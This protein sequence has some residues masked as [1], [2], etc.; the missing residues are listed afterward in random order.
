MDGMYYTTFIALSLVILSVFYLSRFVYQ[1]NSEL[2][3]YFKSFRLRQTDSAFIKKEGSKI[4]REL[5]EE[6]EF[7]RND[8]QNFKRQKEFQ[9][10]LSEHLLH[11][12]N[13]GIL[14]Y[15][16]SGEI[17][18][19]NDPFFEFTG[20]LKG[21][22]TKQVFTENNVISEQ[23]NFRKNQTEFT[24]R[25][26]NQGVDLHLSGRRFEV[27][28]Q[29]FTIIS[30][31]S[32]TDEESE[33]WESLENYIRVS[34]HELVNAI[35][36]LVAVIET[37][38]EETRNLQ[39]QKEKDRFGT[40]LDSLIHQTNHILQFSERN[41]R[42]L[43]LDQPAMEFRSLSELVESLEQLQALFPSIQITIRVKTNRSGVSVDL[44]QMKTVFENLVL[45]AIR[46]A[47]TKE[48]SLL[49]IELRD[50]NGFLEILF[51]DN[52]KGIPEKQHSKIFSP[53]VS[54]THDGTGIGLALC[55]KIVHNHGGRIYLQK[56]SEQGSVFA[57]LLR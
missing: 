20:L 15:N 23:I 47:E 31:R 21:K 17:Y 1:F 34:G 28:G 40:G 46:A 24:T 4:T 41:R 27:Q 45:N 33:S 26:R 8:L 16:D 11:H 55:R 18:F 3:F 2:L 10:T 57:V 43:Q 25:L 7:L 39:N 19:S 42:F 38:Q 6:L 36:P 50:A 13:E 51:T 22:N 49:E 44:V 54:F 37:L 52:G 5:T 56:S 30:I 9:E 12:L 35:T 53:F 48:H 32:V 14:L 29:R